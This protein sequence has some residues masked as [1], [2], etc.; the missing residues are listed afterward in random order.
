[1]KRK[2]HCI[3]VNNNPD[4]ENITFKE[5]S[6]MIGWVNPYKEEGE[7]ISWDV[8]MCEGDGFSCKDQA[9]AQIIAGIEEIKAMKMMMMKI[10]MGDKK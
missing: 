10:K 7:D 8:T 9:T 2:I 1:M 3:E 6:E 4:I 5:L